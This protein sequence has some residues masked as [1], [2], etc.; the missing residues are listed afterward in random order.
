M[1]G[2]AVV[3]R[4]GTWMVGKELFLKNG[5][6]VV[7]TAPPDFELLVKKFA[8]LPSPKFTGDWLNRASQYGSGLTIIQSAQCPYVAKSVKE[9]TETAENKYG[10]KPK[11]IL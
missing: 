1:H 4:K 8:D 3:T 5:F 2:V 10:I 11:I 7:D 6:E 9:I